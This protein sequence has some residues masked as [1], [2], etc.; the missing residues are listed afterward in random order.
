MGTPRAGLRR[1][2]VP[3]L[4]PACRW[5]DRRAV[6]LHGDRAAGRHDRRGVRTRG[7]RTR[8]SRGVMGGVAL[9]NVPGLV[10]RLLPDP[11]AVPHG[12]TL[13]TSMAG[14]RLAHD[15]DRGGRAPDVGAGDDARVHGELP[16]G[17][18]SA[19][20]P[21]RRNNGSPRRDRRGRHVDLIRRVGRRDR[22][23]IP[24]L[25]RGGASPDE[26]VRRGLCIGGGRFH[27]GLRHASGQPGDRLR[28][29][30][31][32]SRSPPASRS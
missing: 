14:P 4:A 29:A 11:A 25:R 9:P 1:R 2:R 27:R 19:P 21:P 20:G 3:P 28:V 7:G 24:T 15:R 10:A 23:A 30:L 26:V 17:G 16:G 6:H 8:S 5:G 12:R 13:V 18:A 22:P 31:P 32:T